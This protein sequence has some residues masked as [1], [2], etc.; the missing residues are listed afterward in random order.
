MFRRIKKLN[1]LYNSK[2]GYEE[3]YFVDEYDRGIID[4][5]AEHYDDLFSYYDMD[6]KSIL[7]NEFIDF[8]EMKADSIP[9][10]KDLTLCFHIP[11]ANEEKRLEIEKTL[12]DTYIKQ[13]HA[14]NRKIKEN[15]KFSLTML[16]VG[17]ALSTVYYFMNM[18]NSIPVL[19]YILNIVE[20]CAWVFVWEAVDSYFLYKRDLEDDLLKKYRFIQSR[21]TIKE[22]FSTKEKK[23]ISNN[24][25]TL[26]NII[27]NTKIMEENNSK[28]E[29]NSK[30]A[31]A[32]LESNNTD[33]KD[34]DYNLEKINIDNNT[35]L[36]K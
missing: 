5:G 17:L 19:S 32:D 35:D 13:T 6:G 2:L 14:I 7:D 11:D 26:S 1:S 3:R 12:K 27:I 33:L 36:E 28:K 10:H 21:I 31:I 24:A 25:K 15:N 34:I 9:P 8:I 20:I 4:V 16:I 22:Y 30:D 18:Y 29:N 23:V